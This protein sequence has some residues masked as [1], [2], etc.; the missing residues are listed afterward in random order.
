MISHLATSFIGC[1][2]GQSNRLYNVSVKTMVVLS[3]MVVLFMRRSRKIT[4]LI[5]FQDCN[6]SFQ[7][8]FL[9]T[10]GSRKSSNSK[11]TLVLFPEV[12]L[13]NDNPSVFSYLFFS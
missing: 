11:G 5:P 3:S 6:N 1:S 8:A 10:L 12:Y 4:W 9:P 7:S 13:W 2:H